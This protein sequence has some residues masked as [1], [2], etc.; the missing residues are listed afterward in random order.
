MLVVLKRD[1]QGP[2]GRLYEKRDQA[3]NIPDE[4]KNVLPT[5][6]KVISKQDF[7]PETSQPVLTLADHDRERQSSDMTQAYKNKRAK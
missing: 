5:D 6:A 1:F 4:F 2:D 3:V 7:V